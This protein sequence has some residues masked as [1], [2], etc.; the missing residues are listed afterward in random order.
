MEIFR[1]FSKLI[2]MEKVLAMKSIT[3]R[4]DE[5]LASQLE[6][7]YESKGGGAER[8]IPGFM[9]IRKYTVHELHG[10]FT[11]EEFAAIIASQNGLLLEPK[12]QANGKMLQAH[13]E[14]SEK[15]EGNISGNSA[16]LKELLEKVNNLT[17]AQIYFLQDEIEI[18]WRTGKE[19]LEKFISRFTDAKD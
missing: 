3:F 2:V 7:L 18:F 12:V 19:T 16:K 6:D 5:D 11:K 10:V 8:I 15:Y 14:D 1:I 13:L 4:A 17:A 9:T